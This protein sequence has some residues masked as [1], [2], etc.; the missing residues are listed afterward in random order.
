MDNIAGGYRRFACLRVYV[1]VRIFIRAKERK[2]YGK[3][4]RGKERRTG[5]LLIKIRI[6][7]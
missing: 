7:S 4:V 3:Y 2:E 1:T 6:N 5:A